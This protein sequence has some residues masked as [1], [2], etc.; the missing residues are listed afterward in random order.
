MDSRPLLITVIVDADHRYRFLVSW[1]LSSPQPS[2]DDAIS[3]PSLVISLPLSL[4][5]L[6]SQVTLS[7]R[8]LALPPRL[9]LALLLLFI[10]DCRGTEDTGNWY[11]MAFLE[12][13][14]AL[15]FILALGS[16]STRVSVEARK[17]TL[18]HSKRHGGGSMERPS[19]ER[20]LMIDDTGKI[21]RERERGKENIT[22]LPEIQHECSAPFACKLLLI[23]VSSMT[24]EPS[25][26][27]TAHSSGGDANLDNTQSGFGG[28]PSGHSSSK[29]IAYD[30]AFFSAAPADRISAAIVALLKA[31]DLY[32]RLID[33]A[34]FYTLPIHI[35]IHTHISISI[36]I[37]VDAHI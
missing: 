3:S 2:S 11:I 24:A 17:W 36:S 22:E 12:K 35:Y 9:P 27:E 23:A 4:Y 1:A 5:L 31:R 21:T 25:I 15:I 29:D 6:A 34:P 14:Q 28:F 32:Y 20:M 18:S 10:N 13:L 16:A 7:P 33:R 19:K 8:R 37:S 30:L 26:S